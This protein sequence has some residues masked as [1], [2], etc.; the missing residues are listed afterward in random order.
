[1]AVNMDRAELVKLARLGAEARLVAL[2]R[3]RA[4]ILRTFPDLKNGS[5]TRGAVSSGTRRRPHMSAAAR[6]A[7]SIRMKKY[8][9]SRRKAQT[10]NA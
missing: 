2:E 9:A 8:W 10:K 4:E 1:M 7:V 6:R 3:E 5:V